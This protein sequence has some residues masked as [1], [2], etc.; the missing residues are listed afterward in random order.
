MNQTQAQARKLLMD[1]PEN[2]CICFHKGKWC[3]FGLCR[4]F[5]ILLKAS[6]N[7]NINCSLVIQYSGQY[8]H[9]LKIK[10]IGHCY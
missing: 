7:G 10:T 3:R 8:F 9:S 5:I 4:M 1:V 6:P 2:K